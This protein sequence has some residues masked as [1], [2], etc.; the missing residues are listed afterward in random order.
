MIKGN[1]VLT[2]ISFFEA[3]WDKQISTATS[4]S[5]ARRKLYEYQCT[6]LN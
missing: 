2:D 1:D 6:N 4:A 5:L 3:K